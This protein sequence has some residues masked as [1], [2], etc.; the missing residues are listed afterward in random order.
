[1][2]DAFALLVA[3]SLR[4]T[5]VLGAAGLV[6]L[7]LRRSSASVRHLVWACA[8]AA[9]L[10]TPALLQLPAVR[11]SMPA[12]FTQ[13]LPSSLPVDAAAAT[14]YAPA[15]AVIFAAAVAGS[16]LER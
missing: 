14:P 2:T 9:V 16:P 4:V 7:A 5:V 10:L 12:A 15:S 11:V 1:M 6:A 13:P 3:A 8:V